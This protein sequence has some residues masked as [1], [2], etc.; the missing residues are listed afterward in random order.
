MIVAAQQLVCHDDGVD[1]ADEGCLMLRQL[2]MNIANQLH[3]SLCLRPLN[4][5]DEPAVA[6]AADA[7]VRR[8]ASNF[9][10]PDARIVT[11]CKLDSLPKRDTLVKARNVSLVGWLDAIPDRDGRS[12]GACISDESFALR[13]YFAE[14]GGSPPLT[15]FRS[16]IAVTEWDERRDARG[17]PEVLIRNGEPLISIADVYGL[18]ALAKVRAMR[19]P[20][21]HPLPPTTPVPA[22]RYHI[23]GYVTSVSP[24]FYLNS[25]TRSSKSVAF[26]LEVAVSR[27]FCVCGSGGAAEPAL[28]YVLV[29]GASLLEHAQQAAGL[30][31]NRLDLLVWSHLA[32][33][34]LPNALTG[35]PVAVV[36]RMT[37]A[38]TQWRVGVAKALSGTTTASKSGAGATLSTDAVD[39]ESMGSAVYIC[40]RPHADTVR[41][42]LDIWQGRLIGSGH[43]GTASSA[44][45]ALITEVPEAVVG[46]SSSCGGLTYAGRVSRLMPSRGVIGSDGVLELDGDMITSVWLGRAGQRQGVQGLVTMPLNVGVDCTIKAQCVHPIVIGPH[47]V[48]VGLWGCARSS[49]AV[50]AWP[51]DQPS[52]GGETRHL[53]TNTNEAVVLVGAV[54]RYLRSIAEAVDET[55]PARAVQWPSGYVWS[56][57][58]LT[59]IFAA[60]PRTVTPVAAESRTN[61]ATSDLPSAQRFPIRV[62]SNGAD[63]SP[64]CAVDSTLRVTRRRATA[65]AKICISLI[66]AGRLSALTDEVTHRICCAEDSTTLT[67]CGSEGVEFST[68]RDFF[69]PRRFICD[70]S[71]LASALATTA[72]PH[73]SDV[74]AGVA[75]RDNLTTV[76]EGSLPRQP[77][78]SASMCDTGLP[79]CVGPA[80]DHETFNDVAPCVYTPSTLL[81]RAHEVA[82]TAQRVMHS[83]LSDATRNAWLQSY[84]EDALTAA[85]LER[86]ARHDVSSA[87]AVAHGEGATLRLGSDWLSIAIP[88]T[89]P[90]VAD[91][92]IRAVIV[93][94]ASSVSLKNNTGAKSTPIVLRNSTGEA[95]LYVIPDTADAATT[96][97]CDT[98][99]ETLNTERGHILPTDASSP[100]LQQCVTA[101]TS[102]TL[103]IDVVRVPVAVQHTDATT[104]TFRNAL[105]ANP[106]VRPP[107]TVPSAASPSTLQHHLSATSSRTHFLAAAHGTLS[108]AELLMNAAQVSAEKPAGTAGHHS[109]PSSDV[110][111]VVYVPGCEWVTLQ[112]Y[113]PL[114]SAAGTAKR[115]GDGDVRTSTGEVGAN[116]HEQMHS[117]AFVYQLRVWVQAHASTTPSGACAAVPSSVAT[118][119]VPTAH[120][121]P[122]TSVAC[123]LS[124]LGSL[125]SERWCPMRCYPNAAD[126]ADDSA[127]PAVGPLSCPTFSLVGRVTSISTLEAAAF[128]SSGTALLPSARRVGCGV[129][130]MKLRIE[131]SHV[132]VWNGASD[133]CQ[134]AGTYSFDWC[135]AL[136]DNVAVFFDPFAQ[137]NSGELP[138]TFGI[139]AIIAITGCIW[140]TSASCKLYIAA[141]YGGKIIVLA[142]AGGCCDTNCPPR[143]RYVTG[144]TMGSEFTKVCAHVEAEI[145]S[146]GSTRPVLDLALQDFHAQCAASS[147]IMPSPRRLTLSHRV[148]ARD[149]IV[150]SIFDRRLRLLRARCTKVLWA[151]VQWVDATDGRSLGPSDDDASVNALGP[152]TVIMA[153]YKMSRRPS[154][155]PERRKPN[156]TAQS[157][158]PPPLAV[159]PVLRLEAKVAVDDG[160][161]EVVVMLND[162]YTE[163]AIEEF[164]GADLHATGKTATD[165]TVAVA[166][167]TDEARSGRASTHPPLGAA[168]RVLLLP[169]ARVAHWA[170]SA[171]AHGLLK[172]QAGFTSQLQ[173]MSMVDTTA[174]PATASQHAQIMVQK[175]L[176]SGRPYN[177]TDLSDPLPEHYDGAGTFSSTWMPSSGT[178]STVGVALASTPAVKRP[179]PSTGRQGRTPYRNA[180]EACAMLQEEISSGAVSGRP[181]NGVRAAGDVA[182]PLSDAQT[183]VQRFQP[184]AQWDIVAVRYYPKRFTVR[185]DRE[186]EAA[187]M[188]EEEWRRAAARDLIVPILRRQLLQWS[189]TSAQQ[190]AFT[191]NHLPILFLPVEPRGAARPTSSS[192]LAPPLQKYCIEL[193]SVGAT[194]LTAP[195]CTLQALAVRR[196]TTRVVGATALTKLR[197]ILVDPQRDSGLRA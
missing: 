11:P 68:L 152:I 65:A 117:G 96:M 21:P 124:P 45:G 112:S 54:D 80:S 88:S 64:T 19:T 4:A 8:A 78:E 90:L 119:P 62:H 70:K 81:R 33:V 167:T 188:Q 126:G 20:L 162:T 76:S 189:T 137:G 30:N 123:V 72:R 128:G 140:R 84:R 38:T 60:M 105:A 34:K 83:V 122:V 108:A 191:T 159:V 35:A 166:T 29:S 116:M 163:A 145:A 160:T 193:D 61:A 113:S 99:D 94:T 114:R 63:M 136:N 197:Q 82:L 85:A 141:N 98:G 146:F 77:N 56:R 121:E 186:S 25:S 73:F 48:L 158:S 9:L 194:T 103:H 107:Q 147:S 164:A 125:L 187:A 100:V 57:H 27:N 102:F 22:A 59:A 182:A 184:P 32:K 23:S 13:V 101:I 174:V 161:G 28:A 120:V 110:L 40:R 93:G 132:P 43:C 46:D 115:A 87:I 142:Q 131:L 37:E 52:R 179:R 17:R 66:T 173:P 97:C 156:N 178:S 12:R 143:D 53:S 89:A 31:R 106:P 2:L 36:L 118:T 69:A 7:L 111:R 176:S 171:A 1:A 165:S 49:I 180:L 150:E 16:I 95:Q 134:R 151:S 196:V 18:V 47:S 172:M 75:A 6:V 135:D 51:A 144:P 44:A 26:L 42:N 10:T 109:E 15:F 3:T 79:Q 190:N 168:A 181:V 24:A 153:S 5:D 91:P 139:G 104:R 129:A 175:A 58:A 155:A 195:R 177:A 170:L 169:R 133:C 138:C 149:M 67:S 185:G 74:N 86:A 14:G 157:R 127:A 130:G 192:A 50:I 183:S 41:A 148:F 39:V 154:T 71:T 92:M 55:H